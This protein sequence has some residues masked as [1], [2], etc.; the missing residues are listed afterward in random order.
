MRAFKRPAPTRTIVLAWRKGSGLGRPLTAVAG[1]VRE[2]WQA[3]AE[4]YFAAWA[5]A[6]RH[7]R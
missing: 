6:A 2:A 4:N 5:D 1:V 7:S 3:P